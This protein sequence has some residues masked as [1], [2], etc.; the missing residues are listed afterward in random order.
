MAVTISPESLK[1]IAQEL[2]MGMKCFYHKLT[3]ELK[4]FPDEL[5][6]HAGFDDEIWQDT[7]N[8]VEMARQN[9]IAFEAMETDESF[10][11]METFVGNIEDEKIRRRFEDAIT[12][13]KPFQNFK[14]L[15]YDYP[16]LRQQWFLYKDQCHI[17]WVREQLEVYN[18]I[19]EDEENSN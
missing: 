4:S 11:M 19:N 5:K 18:S 14:H 12:F 9:Y 15:L 17:E 13:K 16:D 7:I 3:G 6:G 2:D 10:R 1:E 8:E